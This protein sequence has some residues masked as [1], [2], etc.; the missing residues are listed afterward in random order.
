[1]ID[2]G[3][4]EKYEKNNNNKECRK[5]S[6]GRIYLQPLK[7]LKLKEPCSA[8]EKKLRKF[9]GQSKKKVMQKVAQHNFRFFSLFFAFFAF[10]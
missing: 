9:F 6:E 4:D 7:P 5:C 3:N 10:L 1:M 2:L 8:D